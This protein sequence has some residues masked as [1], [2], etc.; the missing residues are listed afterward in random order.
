MIGVIVGLWVVAAAVPKIGLGAVDAAVEIREEM[1]GDPSLIESI[2][3][4]TFKVS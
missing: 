3:L 1:G 4:D 2:H